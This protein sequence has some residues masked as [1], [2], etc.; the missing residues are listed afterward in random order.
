VILDP[1]LLL[2]RLEVGALG[3]QGFVVVG[4]L[5]HVGLDEELPL[6]QEHAGELAQELRSE[7]QPLLMALLPPRI[8]KVQ[9]SDR[10]GGA[11][12]PQQCGLGVLGEHASAVRQATLGQTLVD[13][14]RPFASNLEANQ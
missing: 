2:E 12:K 10:Q 11:G 3:D 6:G 5:G 7:D 1:R 9:V 14:G 8:G 13:D 4:S